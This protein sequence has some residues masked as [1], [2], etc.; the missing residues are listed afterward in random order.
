MVDGPVRIQDLAESTNQHVAKLAQ[1][2]M[3]LLDITPK[4]PVIRNPKSATPNTAISFS[5]ALIF[6]N[7]QFSDVRIVAEGKE[8]PA[9]RVI[10]A[11][12]CPFF[13]VHFWA[14]HAI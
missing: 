9:H 8:I 1:Q 11:S 3:S 10:L 13:A 5:D 6:G 7:E 14:I 12:R 4:Y 2:L